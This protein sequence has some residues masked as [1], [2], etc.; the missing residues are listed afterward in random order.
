VVVV[1]VTYFF[2]QAENGIRDRNVTGV[3]TCALPIFVCFGGGVLLDAVGAVGLE[4]P[5]RALDTA[6]ILLAAG[7]IRAVDEFRSLR[8]TGDAV[9]D[10]FDVLAELDVHALVEDIEGT[11]PVAGGAEGLTVADD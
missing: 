10:R 9:P 3:Q 6:Q 4:P 1:L 7:E 2:F 11:V 5:V 8:L